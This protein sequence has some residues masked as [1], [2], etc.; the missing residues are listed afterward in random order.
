VPEEAKVKMKKQMLIAIILLYAVPVA[1]A[2]D[3]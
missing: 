2:R 1:H 3:T